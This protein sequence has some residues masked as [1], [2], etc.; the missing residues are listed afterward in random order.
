M[1]QFSAPSPLRFH[2]A[3]FAVGKDYQIIFLTETKGLGK[4]EINGEIYQNEE[5]GLIQY[6]NVHKILVDGE[7]LNKAGHYTV[8]FT[9]YLDKKPYF[10][11]GVEKI[12]INYSFY[13]L[14]DRNLRIFHF[15]DTHG[16]TDTPID[17][18]HDTGDCDMIIFNG[19]ISD[20]SYQISDFDVLFRLASETSKGERPMIYAR[21]NHDTRGYAAQLLPDYIP[22]DFRKGRRETFYT[23]RQ[24]P[25]WGLVLDCGEDK[26]DSCQEY[27]G[28]VSF[29]NFRKRETEFLR[30]ILEQAKSEYDAPGVRYK[31]VFCHIPF[32]EFFEGQFNIE[33]ET[34]EEWTH[35]LNEMQIHL[36][37]A[38]HMHSAYFVPSHTSGYRDSAFPTAVCSIPERKKEDGTEFYTGG[39]LELSP[40]EKRISIIPFGDHLIL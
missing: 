27:G 30:S 6:G 19:D 15:A 31:I 40:E 3:V 39:L 37:V 17:L 28:T 10:P 38:G 32:I 21:G 9:E 7:Q 11:V 24:G 2:P 36:L 34:Y 16:K 29:Q 20:S 26:K 14:T 12:R 35:L 8:V 4:I 33:N 23:F 18:Y 5:G 25:L 13:P 22:T 1:E